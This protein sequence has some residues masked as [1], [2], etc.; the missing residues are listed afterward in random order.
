MKVHRQKHLKLHAKL[1]L[2]DGDR[3]LM[4]SQ[5]IDRSAFD[6]RRELGVVVD[7]A[8]VVKRLAELFEHD[9]HKGEKYEAPDPLAVETHDDGELPHDPHFA[10]E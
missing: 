9:W 4:G 8:H 2:A 5:N 1:L 6:L 10:H 3:A 7:D